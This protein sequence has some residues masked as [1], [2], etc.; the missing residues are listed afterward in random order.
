[1]T[2]IVDYMKK[3]HGEAVF[4]RNYAL[5]KNT[6]KNIDEPKKKKLESNNTIDGLK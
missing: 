5:I 2:E 6:E 4:K 3:L 1:M